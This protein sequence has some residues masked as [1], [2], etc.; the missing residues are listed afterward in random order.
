MLTRNAW[1]DVGLRAKAKVAEVEV[2]CSDLEEHR[3]RIQT[4]KSDMPGLTLP[5]WREV[6]E[7]DYH[8]WDRDHVIVDTAKRG[9]D[10]CIDSVRAAVLKGSHEQN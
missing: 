4:R 8:V 3:R 1:R 7:R 2:V 9:V 5:D 6:M 10:E